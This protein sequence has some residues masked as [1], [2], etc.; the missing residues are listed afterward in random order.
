MDPELV[1]LDPFRVV[2]ITVRT[3]NAAEASADRAAIPGLWG[4]FFAERIGEAVGGAS[5]QAIVHGVYWD[6]ESDA[7]GAYNVTVG[8]TAQASDRSHPDLSVIDIPGGSYLAFEATGAPQHVVPQTWGHIWSYFSEPRP[9][10]R[11]FTT[12]FERYDGPE[13]VTIFIAV[14]PTGE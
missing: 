11:T 6:Y 1:T 14:A 3:T 4:R 9:M 13:S 10:G 8:V 7:S 5:T 2:G 12:D